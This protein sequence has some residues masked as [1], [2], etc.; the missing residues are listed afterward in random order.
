MRRRISG[1]LSAVLALSLLVG[2]L[3]MQ[4]PAQAGR[5]SGRTAAAGGRAPKGI[6]TKGRA[7][8]Y[9]KLKPKLSKV[10]YK[11]NEIKRYECPEGEPHCE[12]FSPVMSAP[13]DLAPTD[14]EVRVHIEIVRPKANKRYPVILEASPYHGTIADRSGTRIFPGPKAENIPPW[15]DSQQPHGGVATDKTLGLA[16]Y[17]APRGYAVVF[18]DLRGTGMSE[19]CLDHL[20]Q[21]DKSDLKDV[22]DWIAKQKWSNGRVGMTG[23]SY[24]GSTPSVAAAA[25]PKALKTIVPSAGLAAMY[26]HKFQHGVPYFLQWVGPAEAYEELAINRF[27]PSELGNA[28][29][30]SEGEEEYLGEIG[31]GLPNSAVVS[32]DDYESGRYD[33][34]TSLT[35]KPPAWDTERDHRKGVTK[36]KIPIF[37]VHG[38]NDNAARIPALDWF[39]DRNDR[40][41]DKAWIGQWDHG[42]NFYPV[43]RT[44]GQHAT[45][46][47][48]PNDQWTLA[49]HAWFDKHLMQRKVST[50]PPYELFMNDRKTVYNAGAW[51]PRPANKANWFYLSPET[52]E[53]GLMTLVPEAKKGDIEPGF[54]TFAGLPQSNPVLPATELDEPSELGESALGWESD[55]MKKDIILAGIPKQRLFATF[56]PG[57][58]QPP[59]V[60]ATMYDIAPDGSVVCV[61][62]YS[63]FDERCGISKG[64]FAMNP[65]LTDDPEDEHDN[66]YKPSKKITPPD[67]THPA[68][69]PPCP[70]GAPCPHKYRLQTRGMA[71]AYLLKK[72]HTL[73]LVVATSQSDKVA[74][75]SL[76]AVSIYMGPDDS[77]VGVPVVRNARLR[78]DSFYK[79]GADGS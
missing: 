73:R 25:A 16:G 28:Y 75:R 60:I 14:P 50:G 55:P 45:V 42:S 7:F 61:P 41:G 37:A 39:H 5:S 76:G 29:G 6:Y 79:L 49:L 72:G 15:V 3:L 53:N 9:R 64:T 67:G 32:A 46:I 11:T 4:A 66:I 34:D 20:G 74:T 54:E 26:H 59:H 23:H 70:A 33:D 47:A 63:G 40:K 65:E 71:Q 44:C 52:Q 62:L 10:K 58:P 38:V 43:E 56:A 68:F 12:A 48:C 27:L 35:P 51:P 8:D 13:E 22:I 57:Q 18:M 2:G 19:G 24:V 36:A 77:R 31:C 78:K 30:E 69:G 1:A 17:F 21:K